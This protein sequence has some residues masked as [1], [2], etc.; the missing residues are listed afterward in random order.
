MLRVY[1]VWAILPL[2]DL[3]ALRGD[4]GECLVGTPCAY[5]LNPERGK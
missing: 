1:R 3:A 2:A 4:F 5:L